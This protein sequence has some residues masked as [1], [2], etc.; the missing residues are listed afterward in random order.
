MKVEKLIQAIM[1]EA[2]KARQQDTRFD[3][4]HAKHIGYYADL[5][6]CNM[7]EENKSLPELKELARIAEDTQFNYR[8]EQVAECIREE[9]LQHA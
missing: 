5:V 4:T 7:R 2:S 1:I 3:K 6:Y 9:L 8:G